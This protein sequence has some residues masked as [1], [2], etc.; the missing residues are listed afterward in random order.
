VRAHNLALRWSGVAAVLSGLFI[1]VGSVIQVVA[2]DSPALAITIFNIGL[3]TLIFALTGISHRLVEEIGLLGLVV[4]AVSVTGVVLWISN[5]IVE[6]YIYPCLDPVTATEL[7]SSTWLELIDDLGSFTVLLGLL[8][9]ALA[10][11]RS[12]HLP[13]WAGWLLF[14]GTLLSASGSLA[15]VT[16]PSPLFFLLGRAMILAGLL[17]YSRALI[18]PTQPTE[19]RSDAA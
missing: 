15:L 5:G 16:E 8:L 7:A 11:A 2:D 6:A 18:Q 17:L 19:A 10:S 13:R 3:M 12:R 4:Y 1:V 9:V 14:F